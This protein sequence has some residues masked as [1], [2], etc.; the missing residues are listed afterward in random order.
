MAWGMMGGEINW[1]ALHD[2][3]EY[4]RVKDTELLIDGLLLLREVKLENER[5]AR[6][7]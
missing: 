3:A 1:S 2:I 5:A 4:L 7:G 6:N